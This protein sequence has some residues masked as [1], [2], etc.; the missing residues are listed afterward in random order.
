MYAEILFLP[1]LINKYSRFVV[2]FVMLCGHF[3]IATT[4]NMTEVSISIILF[5]L[6]FQKLYA[7]F[8]ISDVFTELVQ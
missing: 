3:G 7:T 1:A 2:Y 8:L 6:F 5:D 4:T